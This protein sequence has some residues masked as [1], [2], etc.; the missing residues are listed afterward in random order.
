MT[1]WQVTGDVMS[2]LCFRICAMK[3]GSRCTTRRWFIWRTPGAM[4]GGI[5]LS[6]EGQWREAA[7]RTWERFT[8]IRRGPH[9]FGV[10]MIVNHE[11]FEVFNPLFAIFKKYMFIICTFF[12]GGKIN[13]SWLTFGEVP[14]IFD[15][16]NPWRIPWVEETGE[17][18]LKIPKNQGKYANI[19]VIL[20]W[21]FNRRLVLFCRPLSAF[22]SFLAKITEGM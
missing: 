21:I 11:N 3:S 6:W 17:E 10:A 14:M 8:P 13:P 22:I 20:R 9:M 5:L 18:P 1:L 12:F 19:G 7:H 4:D 2:L 16:L 15:R